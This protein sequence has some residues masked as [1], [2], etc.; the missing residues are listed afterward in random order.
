MTVPRTFLAA[1]V[2]AITVAGSATAMASPASAGD[3][4]TVSQ[5]TRILVGAP[6]HQP[7]E[8]CTVGYNAR[9]VSFTAAHCGNTGDYV[10]LDNAGGAISPPL[11]TLTRSRN[12]HVDTGGGANDWAVITWNPSVQLGPNGY[13]GNTVLNPSALTPGAQVC[14]YGSSTRRANCG[15]FVGNV[16]LVSFAEGLEA[17]RGDSGG[18]VWVE[19]TGLIGVLSG[20]HEIR[21]PAA[22]G[23]GSIGGVYTRASVPGFDGR[24]G[25][26]DERAA[27]ITAWAGMKDE[28]PSVPTVPSAHSGS[29]SSPDAST[30]GELKLYDN[31][32]AVNFALPAPVETASAPLSPAEIWGIA[33]GVIALIGVLVG[34]AHHFR[35]VG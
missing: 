13:S 19:G 33:L 6:G 28:V 34:L 35:L 9:S 16:D 4:Y 3:V 23:G 17:T 32:E 22:E 31:D 18:P 8:A 15:R 11:G 29:A 20:A 30:Q 12:S 10:Y 26:Y 1:A 21:V 5:G 25:S 27:L 14:M 7:G 24:P 2:A